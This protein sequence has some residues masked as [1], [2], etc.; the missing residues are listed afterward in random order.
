[1]NARKP[2][3][4]SK[5]FSSEETTRLLDLVEEFKPIGGNMWDRVAFEYNPIPFDER[6]EATNQVEER[7]ISSEETTRLLDLVEE[8][9]PFGGNMWDRVAFEYNRTGLS[10]WPERDSISLRHH[11]QG[12][13]NKTKPT[14]TVYCPPNI[15]RAKR[16]YSAIESKVGAMELHDQQEFGDAASERSDAGSDGNIPQEVSEAV[17][18]LVT[19]PSE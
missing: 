1:M 17:E 10:N 4:K 13:N 6:T 9:K 19:T 8:F 7:L 18:E 5:D 16:L 15:E 11:F 2:R 3:T 12:L 14:G